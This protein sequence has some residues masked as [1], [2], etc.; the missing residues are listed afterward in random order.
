MELFSHET[1]G[2]GPEAL[3]VPGRGDGRSIYVLQDTGNLFCTG[4]GSFSY[5]SRDDPLL[6]KK[7]P[8]AFSMNFLSPS[9]RASKW[10]S[11]PSAIGTWKSWSWMHC[12]ISRPASLRH[13]TTRS[14]N[15]SLTMKIFGIFVYSGNR[16]RPIRRLRFWK[17]LLEFSQERAF[18]IPILPSY[19][20]LTNENEFK[21]WN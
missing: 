14:C 6:R 8:L 13:C 18:E 19:A 9:M 4:R 21:K 10:F 11:K 15:A 3:A 12:L 2:I 20:A 1:S 5:I 16:P 17:T 7:I